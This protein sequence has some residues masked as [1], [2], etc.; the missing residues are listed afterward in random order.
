M[1]GSSH[2]IAEMDIKNM[3]HDA[4]H[5]IRIIRVTVKGPIK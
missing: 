2:D 1:A 5:C 3:R 4:H